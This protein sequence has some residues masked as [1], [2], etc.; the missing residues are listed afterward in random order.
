MKMR[1]WDPI[2]CDARTAGM[3]LLAVLLLVPAL[4]LAQAGP[5]PMAPTD[6][7]QSTRPDDYATRLFT[8]LLGDFFRS[9]LAAIGGSPSLVG[10]LFLIFNS[11]I[12]MIGMIWAGYG[13]LSGVAET[14][15]KGEVL[16]RKQSVVWLPIR[17]VTGIGGIVPVFSGFSLAQVLIV[18]MTA[19][20]IGI[21]NMMW[22][23][24]VSKTNEFT[25]LVPPSA[26]VTMTGDVGFKDVARALFATQV[27]VLAN[28]DFEAELSATGRAAPERIKAM[29]SQDP[30][31]LASS[32]WG[33]DTNPAQCGGATLLD[34]RKGGR[35]ASAVS[36]FRVASVNYGAY[37]QQVQS[38][39]RAGFQAFDQDV[40]RIAAKWWADRRAAN[41]TKGAAPV[42]FPETDLVAAAQ[43]YALTIQTLQS[44]ASK[45]NLGGLTQEALDR[46]TS[47]GW[48][49]AGA[50]YATFAEASA[51]LADAMRAVRF[52]VLAPAGGME[53]AVGEAMTAIDTS[54]AA[55]RSGGGALRDQ[56]TGDSFAVIGDTLSESM[57]GEFSPTTGGGGGGTLGTPTGNLSLGQLIVKKAIDMAAIGSGGGGNNEGFNLTPDTKGFVNPIIMFK[58]M[59]DYMATA[60]ATMWALAAAAK[61]VGLSDGG[62]EK[63]GLASRV[64][65]KVGTKI[66]F[67]GPIMSAVAKLQS[68][69]SVLAPIL[70]IMGLFMAIYIPMIP[71]ITWMGGVIQYTVV[72]C[73]GLVGAPIAALSHLDSEGEGLGRR[74]EAGYMFVLNVLFRPALMLFGFF[75]ASALM[76]V[77]GTVQ[78]SLFLGAM[79]NSQGNA[80]TGFL[81]VV[82]FIMLFFVLNVTLIQGLFNMIFLLPDKVLNMIGSAG[83]TTDLGREVEGKMHGMFMM[84]GRTVREV[85]ASMGGPGRAMARA[86][87]PPGGPR[88]GA[89]RGGQRPG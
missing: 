7:L 88:P 34:A 52:D 18:S 1:R 56:S 82:G 57:W 12:F 37:S 63:A 33:T 61:S 58:N 77:L 23:G 71:F 28:Q 66:P 46:M 8:F 30:L 32:L 35:T 43:R 72:V 15:D 87:A 73:E 5:T 60:G 49:Q 80:V 89:P 54:L 11:A 17:M 76:I 59:G 14:A 40:R 47:G 68:L 31:T 65:N 21:G 20:G 85:G 51:S 26:A 3:A 41:S 42:E 29:P 55:A 39:Y 83:A 9:P 27:C 70:I 69:L 19:L 48:L 38:A 10:A 36:A 67:V 6:F 16:G 24:A 4:A 64:V 50:W 45:A 2:T 84:Y 44:A 86:A 13:L 81:S 78:V 75:I 22:N 25:A 53:G 79:S 74:T 62:D